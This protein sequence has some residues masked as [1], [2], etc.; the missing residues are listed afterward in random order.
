[1]PNDTPAPPGDAPQDVLLVFEGGGAKGLVHLGA[2]HAIHG[3]G[4]LRPRAYAGT[5]AG[6]M[7]A[8]LAAVG[9]QPPDL[10][11]IDGTKPPP[12]PGEEEPASLLDLLGLASANE[13]FGQRGWRQLEAFRRIADAGRAIA[14]G[15][16]GWLV[17]MVVL[18]FA[19]HGGLAFAGLFAL[20]VAAAVLLLVLLGLGVSL[21]PVRDAFETA[22]AQS[23]AARDGR[24][25]KAGARHTFR[26]L[27]QAGIVLKVCASNLSRRR[28]EVFSA[29][30]TPDLPV[31]EAVAA[32]I[33]FPFAFR[34][35]RI[36]MPGR[37]GEPPWTFVDGGLLSNLPAW[38]LDEERRLDP[39]LLTLAVAIEGDQ[40]GNRDLGR[41][42]WV[43]AL[44]GTALVGGQNLSLRGAGRI[45]VLRLDTR[46]R[47]FDFDIGW[48]DAVAA[49][50]DAREAT[51]LRLMLQVLDG[52]E[53][54]RRRNEAARRILLDAI[55]D[56]TLP[57]ATPAGAPA[58]R[59]AL[60]VPEDHVG[61][62]FRHD[63]PP[64]ALVR[65]LTLRHGVGY[66][67]TADA[68]M[69]IP[70]WGS[71]TGYAWYAG[72][73]TLRFF[74]PPGAAWGGG[75]PGDAHR[76][77]RTPP[78]LAWSFAC[79]AELPD[80]AGAGR[81]VTVALVVDGCH[82]PGAGPEARAAFEGVLLRLLVH[83]VMPLLAPRAAM[84]VPA[85]AAL[86]V[87][88]VSAAEDRMVAVPPDAAPAAAPTPRADGATMAQVARVRKIAAD[89]P[90]L[91]HSLR[92]ILEPDSEPGGAAAAP[93]E[94]NAAP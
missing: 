53:E 48:R 50:R 18:G 83:R 85:A 19:G 8:T 65:T 60:A 32:S 35:R 4:R 31:A 71:E 40:P 7:V 3:T 15:A 5:S 82:A 28:L 87:R 10:L 39:A 86:R 38:C 23:P 89:D 88:V 14:L 6:A 37:V 17:L 41:F 33:C 58:I 57:G 1:M 11:D 44:L 36:A 68:G 64:A 75:A 47:V 79:Q 66:G 29:E 34:P 13:L 76:R 61:L 92:D 72:Q 51:R 74:D 93:A 52:R 42:G 84:P 16:L 73:P 9:Y 25:H 45:E 78:A 80:L 63:R 30:T 91:A 49:V 77:A 2:L 21:D 24:L 26:D 22:I 20:G 67:G 55:A 94:P 90:R 12:R 59:V 54:A 70:V 62:G 69:V 81:P 27:D 43:R 46:V 56:G